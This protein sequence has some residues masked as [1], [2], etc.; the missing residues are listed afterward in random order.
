ML[1][2]VPAVAAAQSTRTQKT[3]VELG[4]NYTFGV[5][6]LG[7][8]R[9]TYRFGGYF[10]MR[11]NLRKVPVD[12]GWRLDYSMYEKY[13]GV[14]NGVYYEDYHFSPF[15]FLAVTN[16]SFGRGRRVNPYAGF[17]IGVYGNFSLRSCDDCYE[18]TSN[19][20]KTPFAFVPQIGVKFFDRIN[21]SV[22]YTFT[23]RNWQHASL[24]LGYYF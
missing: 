8:K 11:F 22:S 17:G 24:R 7:A 1:F 21:L 12:I 3:E 15:S 13:Y 2:F 5:E 18:M 9:V 23:D 6:P 20:S 16:Y 19:D 14:V 4:A 10:E